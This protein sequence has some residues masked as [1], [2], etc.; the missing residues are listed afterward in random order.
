MNRHRSRRAA[1]TVGVLTAVLGS[2]LGACSVSAPQQ[3]RSSGSDHTVTLVT[4]DAWALPKR[5]VTEFEK[6]S[7]YTLRVVRNGD[8]GALTNKLVLT[9]DN[10]LGD[11]AYGVDNTFA[12]RAVDGGVFTDYT[13]PGQPSAV[14]R[15][16]LSGAAAQQL[17]PVDWGD[18]CV[19]VDDAW[20]RRHHLAEPRTLDDLAKPAYRDLFVTP[21]ASTSSPGFAFL[22]ATVAAYG[23]GWRDYWRTLVANGTRV[24]NSWSDAYETDF[25]A[26]GGNGDRPIVVS[27][28]SS[29]PFTIPQGGRRPTTSALLDTCFRQVEYAGVLSGSHDPVG[30]RKLVDFLASRD[31]QEALPDAM[32][33]FPVDPGAALPSRWARWAPASPHPYRVPPSDITRHRSA[34]IRQWSDLVSG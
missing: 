32:Y 33:V 3:D 10:P 19:N 13:A 25:T 26:G 24:V 27:Y 9:K 11:V 8:A 20:F 1:A 30:A 17:T 2:A 22:L 5:L 15:Y 28:N 21:G 4:H 7:G 6:Q 14:D 12:T 18:V 16:R 23:E 31:V 34:W 29:P